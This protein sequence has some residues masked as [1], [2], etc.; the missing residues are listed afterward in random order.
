V[1]NAFV[2]TVLEHILAEKPGE[3]GIRKVTSSS[4]AQVK[5]KSV[6]MHGA[7]DLCALISDT[8]IPWFEVKVSDDRFD[9]STRSLLSAALE[10]WEFK[11]HLDFD[12]TVLH[13]LTQRFSAKEVCEQLARSRALPISPEFI[14][15]SLDQ[16][17]ILL[18]RLG[19]IVASSPEMTDAWV[20][21]LFLEHKYRD[22]MFSKSL[23]DT[24]ECLEG[25][26]DLYECL[27]PNLKNR[28]RP[29]LLTLSITLIMAA[30]FDPKR[31]NASMERYT[32]SSLYQ[33]TRSE[34]VGYVSD[35]FSP[36]RKAFAHAM[37]VVG[38]YANEG[39][40]QLHVTR[41][42][43]RARD[44]LVVPAL[45][46]VMASSEKPAFSL[47]SMVGAPNA[48]NKNIL[49]SFIA[50]YLFRWRSDFAD[51]VM[52]H[53]GNVV[54]K[55]ALKN[56]ACIEHMFSQST[57][58]KA[59]SEEQRLGQVELFKRLPSDVQQLI[60]D[61]L[62]RDLPSMLKGRRGDG[63]KGMVAF[64]IEVPGQA[65]VMRTFIQPKL[66][67]LVA[68]IGG[69]ESGHYDLAAAIRHL[70]EADVLDIKDIAK[71]ISDM[72]QLETAVSRLKIPRES[73]SPHITSRLAEQ[74]IG[75]DLGL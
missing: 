12:E 23:L 72:A 25:G 21:L 62:W 17:H 57:F 73:L 69:N 19:L 53:P 18:E 27:D 65:D 14:G 6:F 34:L 60:V 9:S 47:R 20:D 46:S 55:R 68:R 51:K 64:I 33:I 66:K 54:L 29:S 32:R 48:L 56:E 4:Y 44:E 30:A 31:V 3:D 70:V 38:N 49:K 26:T 39:F 36:V 22:K 15:G 74:M 63:L 75:V 7:D 50:H 43:I 71:S 1:S 13:A 10:N 24:F 40:V 8:R 52:E 11:S 67:K 16:R 42:P 59:F 5:G 2:E 28:D 45:I 58:S 37:Y 61:R 41:E 35:H